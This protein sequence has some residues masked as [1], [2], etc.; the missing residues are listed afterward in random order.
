MEGGQATTLKTRAVSPGLPRSP[1]VLRRENAVTHSTGM[2]GVGWC[3]GLELQLCSW[4]RKAPCRGH[5]NAFENHC[6][7]SGPGWVWELG[8]QQ[9]LQSF[10][11]SGSQSH[12]ERSGCLPF[13]GARTLSEGRSCCVEMCFPCSTGVRS[14]SLMENERLP[15]TQTQTQTGLPGRDSVKKQRADNMGASCG[16][17]GLLMLSTALGGGLVPPGIRRG[18]AAG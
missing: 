13:W 14:E 7:G 2:L 9:A 11:Y 8:R 15:G 4:P 17:P 10:R 5:K 6:S 3:I 16:S 18:V 1:W 12:R